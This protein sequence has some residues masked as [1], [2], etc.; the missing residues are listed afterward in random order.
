MMK[1]RRIILILLI[2]LSIIMAAVSMRLWSM[3]RKISEDFSQLT[4]I[5]PRQLSDGRHEGSYSEFLVSV[6]LE[7]LIENGMIT[8]VNILEQS[9]GP[10]YDAAE[11]AE[12][13]VRRQ[14][15][16][17][18]SVSG[19]TSSSMAIMNAVHRAMLGQMR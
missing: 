5:D 12:V 3:Q 9:S 4:H 2:C 11:T 19:A 16:L 8:A 15:P 18:D 1:R 6:R 10:G 13:I 7:V 17:V 14:T